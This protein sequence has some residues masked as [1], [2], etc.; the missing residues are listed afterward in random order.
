MIALPWFLLA[1]GIV[2]FVVGALLAGLP[3]FPRSRPRRIS[4]RMRDEDIVKSLRDEK[5]ITLAGVM[6]FMGLACAAVSILWRIV[7]V[8]LAH[9]H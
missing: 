7:L 8:V 5:P 2:L 9:L 4:S 6:M 1:I 3:S